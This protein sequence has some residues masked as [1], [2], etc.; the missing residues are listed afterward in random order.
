MADSDYVLPAKTLNDFITSVISSSAPEVQRGLLFMLVHRLHPVHYPDILRFLVKLIYKYDDTVA[1]GRLSRLLVHS[2]DYILDTRRRNAP[3]DDYADSRYPMAAAPPADLHRLPAPRH[4]SAGGPAASDAN[5]RPAPNTG[6]FELEAA[7]TER[8]ISPLGEK[9]C[10][11]A[12]PPAAL[13]LH[14]RPAP[15]TGGFELEAAQTEKNICTTVQIPERQL[16]PLTKLRDNPE[17]QKE[18]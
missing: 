6:G 11:I 12:A 16:R 1:M 10:S 14:R 8:N 17:A 3:S 18:I 5:R 4:R 9:A 13:H 15:N 2:V 7:Q